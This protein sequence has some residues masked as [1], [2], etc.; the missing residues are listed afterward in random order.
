MAMRR[1]IGLRLAWEK[2]RGDYTPA[3]GGDDPSR[4]DSIVLPHSHSGLPGW[5]VTQVTHSAPVVNASQAV[6]HYCPAAPRRLA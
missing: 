1:L 5:R 4:R 6:R 3:L 2:Y